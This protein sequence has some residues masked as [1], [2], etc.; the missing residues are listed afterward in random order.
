MLSSQATGLIHRLGR[1]T[2]FANSVSVFCFIQLN[3]CA[4]WRDPENRMKIGGIRHL[5]PASL[6]PGHLG[7]IR[8]EDCIPCTA[9]RSGKYWD[10]HLGVLFYV[11]DKEFR[12]II[13]VRISNQAMVIRNTA[14]A[15]IF[16]QY[17]CGRWLTGFQSVEPVVRWKYD[18]PADPVGYVRVPHP[19]GLPLPADHGHREDCKSSRVELRDH[20]GYSR[21]QQLLARGRAR[22]GCRPR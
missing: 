19:A 17:Q 3:I 12:E 16:I 22:S 13:P 5:K 14:E 9:I 20:R 11:Q 1:P 6:Q 8:R 4:G 21:P 15:L 7:I 10:F 2:A 18:I